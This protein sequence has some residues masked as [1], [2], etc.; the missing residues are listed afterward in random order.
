[1]LGVGTKQPNAKLNVVGNSATTSYIR[2]DN[3]NSGIGTILG[4]TNAATSGFVGTI[5]NNNFSI[6]TNNTDQLNIS[7]T[8]DINITTSNALLNLPFNGDINADAIRSGGGITVRN[9]KYLDFLRADGTSDATRIY[10]TTADALSLD[11]NAQAFVFKATDNK[12][13]YFRNLGGQTY[14]EFDPALMR[15]CVGCSAPAV[16]LD[17]NGALRVD[18]NIVSYKD[19]NAKRICADGNC[20]SNLYGYTIAVQSLASSPADNVIN[21]FGANPRAVTTT[22]NVSQVYIPRT[23]T[24]KAAYITGYAGTAGTAEAWIMLLRKNNTTDYNITTVATNTSQRVFI[25]AQMNV[26]VS[27]GDYFEIKTLNPPWV[28]NPLTSTFGGHIYIE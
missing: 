23:G 21:Y 20:L 10:R 17:V 9:N 19:V 3:A 11:Y 26:P 4:S 16:T 12:D 7:S 2:V 28:T 27:A 8:G 13:V 1:M 15:V 22:A 25:N 18:Q 24:I 5:T 14:V 6:R